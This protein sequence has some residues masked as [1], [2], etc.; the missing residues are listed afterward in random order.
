MEKVI[1]GILGLLNWIRYC[2]D[3]WILPH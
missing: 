1:N 3:R 2:W